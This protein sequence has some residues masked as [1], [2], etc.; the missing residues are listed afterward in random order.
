MA[1]LLSILHKKRIQLVSQLA[2]ETRLGKLSQWSRK[3]L[4]K[5]AQASR[6]YSSIKMLTMT[7][8]LLIQQETI[9]IARK[10]LSVC[11]NLDSKGSKQAGS[12]YLIAML[13]SRKT[14]LFR[15]LM[16]NQLS[17]QKVVI[18]ILNLKRQPL[19]DRS[20]IILH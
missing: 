18:R 3:T 13:I 11:L 4:G 6:R 1:T 14:Q 7:T 12:G 20:L 19:Q 8:F 2:I 15:R 9:E 10:M 5:S 16:V 17:P